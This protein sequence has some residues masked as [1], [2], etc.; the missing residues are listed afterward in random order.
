MQFVEQSNAHPDPVT[1]TGTRALVN[2]LA[3]GYGL[4]RLRPWA[5]RWE[6]AYVSVL[7]AG[8]AAGTVV[9]LSNPMLT[10]AY[11]TSLVLFL[12][13]F[14]LPYVPFLFGV[15]GDE[16]GASRAG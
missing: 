2:N 9:D 5:R 1:E 14:A 15:V 12:M 8:L 7:S 11:R 3:G 10:P 4:L 16:A 6:V 13:A